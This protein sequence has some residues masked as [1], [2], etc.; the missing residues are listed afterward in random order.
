MQLVASE[1]WFVAVQVA[2]LDPSAKR[3]P[4]AGE[5]DTL[6]ATR[7]GSVPVAE[8]VAGADGTPPVVCKIWLALHVIEGAENWL[9]V[10]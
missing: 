3:D 8:N 1:Y 5:H 10:T 7:D 9:T 2:K 6:G 4:E